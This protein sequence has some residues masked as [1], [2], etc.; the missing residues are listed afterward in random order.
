MP[1]AIWIR[2]K[3]L[4]L[5]LQKKALS[6]MPFPGSAQLC[7]SFGLMDPAPLLFFKYLHLILDQDTFLWP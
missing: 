7:I 3:S 2:V 6:K 4:Y 1:P 5:D